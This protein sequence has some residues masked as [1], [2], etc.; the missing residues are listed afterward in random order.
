VKY[1]ARRGFM[2]TGMRLNDYIPILLEK[3]KHEDRKEVEMYETVG[4]ITSPSG[5]TSTEEIRIFN[6]YMKQANLL[7]ITEAAPEKKKSL[8]EKIF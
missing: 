2:K 8:V 4:G 1:Y 3:R 7:K 6:E 5:A